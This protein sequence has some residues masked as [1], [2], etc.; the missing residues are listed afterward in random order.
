[1]GYQSEVCGDPYIAASAVSEYVNVAGSAG[2]GPLLGLA[3]AT[4]ASPGDPVAIQNEGI[5]KGICAAGGSIRAGQLV[6][7]ATNGGLAEFAAVTA[8]NAAPVRYYVGVARQNA[9]AGD[10]FAVWILP[11]ASI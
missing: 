9:V 5:G 6:T 2:Y 10:R 7:A 4:A 3:L 1:M 8:T 11:G